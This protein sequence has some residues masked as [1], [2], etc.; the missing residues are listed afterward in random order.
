MRQLGHA[1][2]ATGIIMLALGIFF[3]MGGGI[4]WLGRLPGDIM[5]ER[6][7]TRFF[8]PVTTSL[9]LSCIVSLALALYRFL[10]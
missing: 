3:S 7:G 1:L 10:R 9:V 8:F 2:V 4:S 5:I 6:H